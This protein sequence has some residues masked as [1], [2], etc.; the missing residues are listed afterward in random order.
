VSDLGIMQ[1]KGAVRASGHQQ[2]TDHLFSR[3]TT[4]LTMGETYQLC[5]SCLEIP[6]KQMRKMLIKKMRRIPSDEGVVP[7][8]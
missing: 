7:E 8:R 3:P 4:Y 6:T 5:E 1:V 2:V